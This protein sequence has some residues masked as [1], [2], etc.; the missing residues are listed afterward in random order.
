MSIE[1]LMERSGSKCEL[2]SS[3]SNVSVYEVPP[4]TDGSDDKCLVVCDSCLEQI[5][6]PSKMDTNHWHCLNESMWS[7]VPAVQVMAWRILKRLNAEGWAQDLLEQIYLD[8]ETQAW[9]ESDDS[10][11]SSDDV[12]PTVDC[13]GTVLN[14]GDS[15]TLI[16]D[17]DV[18]GTTFVAKRGTIVKNISLT[19]NPEHIEGRINKTK[20]VLKTCFMKKA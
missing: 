16:R 8:E 19:S 9:A 12:K 13:N 17:L 1:S 6:D 7:E 14:D 5:N 4:T 10:D 20:L 15:V 11:D 18:K 2:C 3:A